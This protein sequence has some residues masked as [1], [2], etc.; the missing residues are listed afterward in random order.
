M[1]DLRRQRAGRAAA[2]LAGAA[3]SAAGP[4]GRRP[5]EPAA[6]ELGHRGH[7]GS[8]SGCELI[9]NEPA[10]RL[11][12]RRA[13]QLARVRA[14]LPADPFAGHLDG[15]WRSHIESNRA[16]RERERGLSVS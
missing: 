10:G 8:A 15:I 12:G 14:R 7:L 2:P 16:R 11:A 3:A 13:D 4:A 5:L 6:V 9:S 1:I